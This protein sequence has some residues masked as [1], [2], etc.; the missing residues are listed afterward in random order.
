M[1]TNGNRDKDIHNHIEAINPDIVC[2][3]VYGQNPNSSSANMHGVLKYSEALNNYSKKIFR[4]N[5]RAPCTALPYQTLNLHEQINAVSI[6]EGIYTIHDLQKCNL[7]EKE[8][9]KCSRSFI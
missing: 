7:Q 5:Y 2:Y 9:Y 6:N 4:T 8:I 1:L 3:V